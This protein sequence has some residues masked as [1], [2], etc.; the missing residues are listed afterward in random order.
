METSKLR[1]TPA[2]WEAG[3]QGIGGSHDNPTDVYEVTNH[4]TRICEYCSEADAKL[5]AETG[6]IY[7]E[8]GKT[9]RELAQECGRLRA[10]LVGVMQ[11]AERLPD[12]TIDGE[13]IR[14]EYSEAME[15]ARAALR[16]R[17]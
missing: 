10:A 11:F 16:E 3:C 12:E 9:P 17:A 2:F 13:E 15:K 7:H 5:I 6:N 14:P 4:Y 1:I 8:T